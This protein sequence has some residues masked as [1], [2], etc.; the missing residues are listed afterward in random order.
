VENQGV[1]YYRPR[2]YDSQS[3]RF[4]SE[5]FLRIPDGFSRYDCISLFRSQS[6]HWID[7]RCPPCRNEAGQGRHN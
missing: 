6:L 1:S 4:I 5:D 3:G 2:Y 7:P